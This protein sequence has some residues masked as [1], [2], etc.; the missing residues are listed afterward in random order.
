MYLRRG[1]GAKMWTLLLDDASMVWLFLPLPSS[2]RERG[3]DGVS[4]LNQERKTELVSPAADLPE[5]MV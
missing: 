4:R 5:T 3:L 1:R 2:R